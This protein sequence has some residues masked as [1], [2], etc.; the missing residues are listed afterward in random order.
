MDDFEQA[1]AER[2]AWI[3]QRGP[4]VRAELQQATGG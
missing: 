4:A 1:L 2:K 3:A